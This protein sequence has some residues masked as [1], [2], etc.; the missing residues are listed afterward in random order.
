MNTFGF[1]ENYRLLFPLHQKMPS[2]DRPD[3]IFSF[4]QLP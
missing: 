1:K 3:G 4:M 2:G